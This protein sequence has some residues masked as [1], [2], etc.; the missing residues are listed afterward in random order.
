[1]VLA[2]PKREMRERIR[3][4]VREFQEVRNRGEENIRDL[5]NGVTEIGEKRT[6]SRAEVRNRRQWG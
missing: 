3:V 1:M 4:L 2:S 6:S 5:E